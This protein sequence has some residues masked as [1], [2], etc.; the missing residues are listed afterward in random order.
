[1]SRFK[2]SHEKGKE[3][4]DKC[5]PYLRDKVDAA[6]FVVLTD[7]QYLPTET[8]RIDNLRFPDF[9]AINI[10]DD[11]NRLLFESKR[12]DGWYALGSKIY[13]TVE[14]KYIDD[15][16]ELSKKYDASLAILMYCDKTKKAYWI[17]DFS[18]LTEYVFDNKY[19]QKKDDVSYIFFVDDLNEIPELHGC[20]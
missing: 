15:Y 3:F 5:L 6:K 10:S 12:K 11:V 16:L 13:V 17:T 9:I 2:T 14:K 7:K 20:C 8:Y 1:M 18:E 4:Q 19:S